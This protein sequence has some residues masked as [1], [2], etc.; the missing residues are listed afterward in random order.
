MSRLTR[1]FCVLGGLVITTG[2][3]AVAGLP[4]GPDSKP[5]FISSSAQSER[6]KLPEPPQVLLAAKTVMVVGEDLVSNPASKTEQTFKRAII[7]WGHFRLVDEVERSDLIIVILEYSSS[8]PTRTERVSEKLVIFVGGRTPSV[9]AAP[10][11]SVAEVGPA[12]GQRPTSKL[13]DD[14]RKHLSELRKSPP[15]RSDTVG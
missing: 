1:W 4:S 7:R 6:D 13:V 11:W 9:D 8:K 14:L 15:R 2:H 12:L 3:I 5:D 10:L